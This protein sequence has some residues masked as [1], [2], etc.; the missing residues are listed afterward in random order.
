MDTLVCIGAL[1]LVATAA[2]AVAQAV[3]N[4][5]LPTPVAD[6]PP[7]LTEAEQATYKKCIRMTPGQQAQSSKCS[8]VMVKAGKGD[9]ARMRGPNG[10]PMKDSKLREF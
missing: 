3:P 5:S 8:K 9:P 1:A 10:S 2:P 7:E 4:I 6:A